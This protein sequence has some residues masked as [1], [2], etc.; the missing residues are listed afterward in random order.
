MEEEDASVLGV[1]R[2]EEF[3]GGLQWGLA[4]MDWGR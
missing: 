3:V 4:E 2:F 1:G